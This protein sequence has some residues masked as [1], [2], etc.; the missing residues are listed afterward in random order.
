MIECWV[1]LELLNVDADHIWNIQ[2]DFCKHVLMQLEE[3]QRGN[4][5]A[6]EIAKKPAMMSAIGEWKQ[7]K[8]NCYNKGG[9]S[10]KV[11]NKF[12]KLKLSDEYEMIYRSL[13]QSVHSTFAGVVARSFKV[14]F[15]DDTYEAI[16]YRQL[17]PESVDVIIDTSINLIDRCIDLSAKLLL[18]ITHPSSTPK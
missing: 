16:L 2:F 18:P 12:N 7:K 8:E 9:R 14:D 10:L 15:V 1:E 5:I 3:A 6:A 13:S 17:E 4:P 11:E